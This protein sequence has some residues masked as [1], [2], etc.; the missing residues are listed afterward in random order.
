MVTVN[1]MPRLGGY[2]AEVFGK[3]AVDEALVAAPHLHP[4]SMG[5]GVDATRRVHSCRLGQ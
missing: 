5:A 2:Q 4:G 1:G 3:L